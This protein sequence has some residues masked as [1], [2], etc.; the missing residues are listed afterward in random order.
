MK[1]EIGGYVIT[2]D[3]LCVTLNEKKIAQEGKA[4]GEEYLSAIGYYNTVESCMEGLLQHK[5]KKSD[6]TSIKE[7]VDEIK[8]IS[9]FIREQFRK[10]RGKK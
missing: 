1:I 2:S 8:E 6:A 3:S 5:I 10:A 4:K 9:K 7:L